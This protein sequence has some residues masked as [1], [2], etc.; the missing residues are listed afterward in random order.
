MYDYRLRIT[1]LNIISAAP[2]ICTLRLAKLQDGW[3]VIQR[4]LGFTCLSS[5]IST[6]IKKI[7]PKS[8]NRKIT[9]NRTNMTH[10]KLKRIDAASMFSWK[11]RLD[12]LSSA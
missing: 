9:D 5:F 2:M 7:G 8:I 11:D 6:N 4:P 3:S 10:Q 1:A 12:L